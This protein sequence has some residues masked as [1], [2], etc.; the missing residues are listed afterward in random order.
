MLKRR[1]S[2]SNSVFW[3]L[4]AGLWLAMLMPVLAQTSP[5]T[6]EVDR[7]RLTTDEFVTLTVSVSTDQA[8]VPP[9]SLP[10]LAEFNILQSGQSSQIRIIN[11]VLSTEITYYYI[12]RP[13]Q[14]GELVIPEITATLNGQTYQSDP[15][16]LEVTQGVVAPPTPAPQ[17]PQS[18]PDA[19][20]FSGQDFFVEAEVDNLTPFVGEQ[21]LYTFRF[22][23]ARRVAGQPRYEAPSFTGF[24]HEQQDDQNQY[25]LQIS[26]RVYQITEVQTVLFPTRAG[27]IVIDPAELRLSGGFS[28]QNQDFQTEAITVTVRALPPDAPADFRGAVGLFSLDSKLSLNQ[29]PVNEPITLLVTLSGQGNLQT[30]SDPVWPEID[31]WRAFEEQTVLDPHFENGRIVGSKVYERLLVP[32]QA[33]Q[34][35]L[36]PITYSYFDPTDEVY[37][38]LA[39]EVLEVEVVPGDEGTTATFVP[40]EAPADADADSLARGASDIRHIKAVPEILAT[41]PAVITRSIWYW[42]A[43]G[44]PVLLVVANILW[45]RRQRQRRENA[46]LL[47]TMRALP[48]ARRRLNVARRSEQDIYQTMNQVLQTYLSD[49]LGQPVNGLTQVALAERLFEAQLPDELID[50]VLQSLAEA[51]MGRFGPLTARTTPKAYRLDELETLI[52]ALDKA[53]N[54]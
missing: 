39:T 38:S 46:D 33:G 54:A 30:L 31:G 20:G 3:L 12:L 37:R 52:S 49:K 53:F 41:Q 29:V 6:V 13:T 10:P 23:R 21:V 26:N 19:D 24:W 5:L 18:N 44:G 50:Q 48:R 15:I 34:Y 14:T 1:P 11:G 25:T 43:W 42:L 35:V 32:G 7:T 28:G 51:E 4:I 47:R 9:P 45:L 40:P 8:S 16:T 22:Y 2:K 36:P 17:L 27:E